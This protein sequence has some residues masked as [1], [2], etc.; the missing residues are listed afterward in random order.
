MSVTP[1]GCPPAEEL[2]SYL[3][4]RLSGERTRAVAEHVAAC[5]DCG[6]VVEGIVAARLAAVLDKPRKGRPVFRQ[7]LAVAAAVVAVALLA[8]PLWRTLRP[9]D[10]GAIASLVEASRGLRLV[11]SRLTGGFEPGV[12]TRGTNDSENWKIAAVA[13]DLKERLP[14]EPSAADSHVFGVAHLLLGSPDEAVPFLEGA[15]AGAPKE[16]GYK[17][18][19]A[20]A[21]LERA[22]K[23][24]RPEDAVRALSLVEEALASQPRMKE[25]L[26]NRALA[27]EA[28]GRS[29]LAAQ[30]WS[31]YLVED[32][33]S[34]W[35]PLARAHLERLGL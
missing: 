35:T 8:F 34:E 28:L 6:E 23:Q 10:E 17:A 3:D 32:P 4:A 2:A 5:A 21:L 14:Q 11:E 7:A 19:L 26:F 33:D 22:R 29:E 1:P 27:L 15:V 9:P 30:A 25:A 16:A 20:A 12:V 24:S 13:Q 18:D 31:A